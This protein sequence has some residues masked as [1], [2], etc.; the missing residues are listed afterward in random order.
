[1]L[2]IEYESE[3]TKNKMNI[4]LRYVHSFI[5]N[6]LEDWDMFEIT[7]KNEKGKITFDIGKSINGGPIETGYYCT[8]CRDIIGESVEDVLYDFIYHLRN[9]KDKK[10]IEEKIGRLSYKPE[11]FEILLEYLTD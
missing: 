4:F 6:Y 2:N 1:M 10:E 7:L 9:E 11:E 8:I 5:F 3:E